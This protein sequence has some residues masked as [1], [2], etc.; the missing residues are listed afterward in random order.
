MEVRSCHHCGSGKPVN[1]TYSVCVFVAN[2]YPSCN[3]HAPD[4]IVICALSGPTVFFSTLSYK[5]N[6]FRKEVTEH[7]MCVL[8]FSTT[9]FSETSLIL[10]TEGD[11]I[12]NVY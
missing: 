2:R 11:V 3:A 10:R 8:I 4:Y 1:I 5:G 9:F 12:K 6:D 7:K